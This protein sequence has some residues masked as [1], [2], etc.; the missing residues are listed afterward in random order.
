[1]FARKTCEAS[2]ATLSLQL[3]AAD[4]SSGKVRAGGRLGGG[5]RRSRAED[6]AAVKREGERRQGRRA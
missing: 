2:P 1:M 3:R 6:R 5:G 4:W